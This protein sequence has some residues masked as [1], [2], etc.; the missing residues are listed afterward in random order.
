ML[1]TVIITLQAASQA[2]ASGFPLFFRRSSWLVSRKDCT[3]SCKD[4]C[5]YTVSQ[6]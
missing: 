4:F 6:I 2:M 5:V 1:G 3:V